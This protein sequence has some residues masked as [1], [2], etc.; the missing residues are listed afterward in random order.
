MRRLT[1]QGHR[2][3][4][5]T[6][7][8]VIVEHEEEQFED[9]PLEYIRRDLSLNVDASGATR[10]HAA[11][12][13]VRAFLGGNEAEVTSIVMALV[14]SALESY[15]ANPVQNWK[16][17]DTAIYLF[18]S[19]ASLGST[20]SQGVT[21]TNVHVDVVKFFAEHVYSDLEEG[22][23]VHPILQVDAIRFI[24]QF[25]YQVM[26]DYD[27][28]IRPTLTCQSAHKRA[29]DGGTAQPDAPPYFRK[30]RLAYLRCHHH[31]TNTLHQERKCN[32]VSV[33]PVPSRAISLTPLSASRRRTYTRPLVLC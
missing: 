10:R 30:L 20:M 22:K 5:L 14:Q 16:N 3:A 9:D 23:S 2:Y 7:V 31:R 29:T 32:A 25:R 4:S 15:A 1:K 26:Q 33:F 17:K 13:L 19:V 6:L 21:S 12:D 28:E 11:S 24:H 27:D 8:Y 18:T